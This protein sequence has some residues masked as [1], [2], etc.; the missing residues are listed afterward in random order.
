M[1]DG[2]QSQSYIGSVQTEVVDARRLQA[3]Q[4]STYVMPCD[5]TMAMYDPACRARQR[6][7][8]EVAYQG[9]GIFRGEYS[10]AASVTQQGGARPR[11]VH[12]QHDN[13]ANTGWNAWLCTSNVIVPARLV[14]ES[15]DTDFMTR[16]L[17]PVALQTGGYVRPSQSGTAVLMSRLPVLLTAAVLI[18]GEFN[19]W[20][21]V[22]GLGW[23]PTA[24][25]HLLL[26][27]RNG[28]RV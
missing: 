21:E 4:A 25:L 8:L 22:L 5:P 10:S 3:M 15:M 18:T 11:C 16:S 1:S 26:H 9:Y 7:P 6:T 17:V 23:L 2:S 20:R 13:I 27:R 28:P 14:V 12:M 19:E 24:S